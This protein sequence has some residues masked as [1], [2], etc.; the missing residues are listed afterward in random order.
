MLENLLHQVIITV[1]GG[2]TA[3]ALAHLALLFKANKTARRVGTAINVH[4]LVQE[5]ARDAIAWADANASAAATTIDKTLSDAA[6]KNRALSYALSI[7][8][9][10][11]LD[12]LGEAEL[13]KV[14][15]AKLHTA[16]TVP[17]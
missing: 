17:R 2:A 16:A 10:A 9:A 12:K 5:I 6:R 4:A 1:V 7:A 11:G 14:L 15:A 3:W 8:K 13:E